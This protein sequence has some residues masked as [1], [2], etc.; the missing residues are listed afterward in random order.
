MSDQATTPPE[1]GTGTGWQAG[2]SPAKLEWTRRVLG[3]DPPVR[4]N[5]RIGAQR[6]PET[7]FNRALQGSLDGLQ[8][9][10]GTPA[11]DAATE[12]AKALLENALGRMAQAAKAKDFTTAAAALEEAR[13][14][15]ATVQEGFATARDGWP[16]ALEKA[17]APLEE[18][19]G[20]AAELRAEAPLDGPL[21]IARVKAE[22]LREAAEKA[23]AT[24]D[25]R[26][27]YATLPELAEATIAL[28]EAAR[29]EARLQDAGGLFRA[30][31][32]KAMDRLE[33]AGQGAPASDEAETAQG[34]LA[35]QRAR[36]VQAAKARDYAAAGEALDLC[37]AAATTVLEALEAAIGRFREAFAPAQRALDAL[38]ARVEALPR[39]VPGVAEAMAE[40]ERQLLAADKASDEGDYRAAL[41]ACA[42]C[43]RA[44][45][46]AAG[47]LDAAE[48]ALAEA[49]AKYEEKAKAIQASLDAAKNLKPASEAAD[50]AMAELLRAMQAMEAAAGERRYEDAL[51]AAG[52]AEAAAKIVTAERDKAKQAFETAFALSTQAYAAATGKHGTTPAIDKAVLALLKQAEEAKAAAEKARDAGDWRAANAAITPLDEAVKAFETA[53][54]EERRIRDETAQ[55]IADF[56]QRWGT[57]SGLAALGGAQ[58]K[59]QNAYLAAKKKLDALRDKDPASAAAAACSTVEAALGRVEGMAA[60]TPQQKTELVT[61]ATDR[62]KTLSDTDFDKQTTEERATA[63][64]DLIADGEPTGEALAQ[65]KRLY[66][67]SKNDPE[68]VEQRKEQ[69]KK[70]ATKV[71]ALPDAED[72]RD[73][74]DTKS[75]DERKA[76]LGKVLKAQAEELGI[77]EV[78]LDTFSQPRDGG[79]SLLFGSYDPGLKRINLNTHPDAMPDFREAV[80]TVLHEN[81]HA[82]QDVLVQ[83]LL[84]GEIGPGDPNYNQVLYFAA[85]FAPGAYVND[86]TATYD[87]QPIEADAWREGNEGSQAVLDILDG[88]T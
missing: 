41:A 58:V 10:R 87:L 67:R 26:T 33:T 11:V 86:G 68:F 65:L 61:A 3:I 16:A 14:A 34:V 54:A 15:A 25:F 9:A 2:I 28:E 8:A 51:K 60:L 5:I 37:E 79:G 84:D 38:P 48:K 31:L 43:Q 81:T 13:T 24:E 36:M 78:P 70:I 32:G 1:G 55:K 72:M 39:P 57:A 19:L 88:I 17:A 71:A 12:Q 77:P 59:A 69:R 42:A 52:E 47:L 20:L 30:R 45:E 66:D 73:N 18:A 80:N 53:Y 83:K 64:Y 40:A 23:A 46:Q 76:F 35:E 6:D 29:A 50:T 63:V 21:D 82:Q 4:S 74:W 27:A 7:A 22:G 85:N 56:E 49:R 44:A 62:L 75:P